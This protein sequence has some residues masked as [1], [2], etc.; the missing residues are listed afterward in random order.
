M[1]EKSWE[2]HTVVDAIAEAWRAG[3]MAWPDVVLDEA[4]FAAHVPRLDPEAPMRYPT[5]IF[6]AVACLAR[7][8]AAIALFDRDVLSAAR[9]S[10]AAIE[11]NAAF[12]DE[13]MQRVRTS[14]VV[15][16]DG[17]PKLLGYAGRGPLRAWVGITGARAAL[18]MLRSQRRAKE[19]ALD[20]DE[21]TAA[22]ITISTN[23][24]ELELLKRQCAK[25]FGQALQESI[26]GLEPRL[27]S[28][29]KMSFVDGLSID[30]IGAV[31]AVHRATAARWIER[32]RDEVFERTRALL[33]E[34]LAL[35]ETE[36]D[37]MTSLVRSQLDVSLSQL[38]PR[39]TG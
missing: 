9:A 27:R 28:V 18:M 32:A 31:Y 35:S 39:E 23:N 16:D 14:L 11:G 15:G 5:D 3:R 10:I 34:R 8:P 19:V 36:L 12:V 22:L 17:T 30:E 26:A 4:E 2:A 24:P 37:R 1:R 25:A 13:V 29:L 20:S 21:W 33:T 6:L 38:L 7:D